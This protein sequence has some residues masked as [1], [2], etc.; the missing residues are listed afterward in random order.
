ML[1][2]SK[3]L[4]IYH[5]SSELLFWTIIS[6]AARTSQPEK[7]FL[8]RLSPFLT[9]AVGRTLL[10]SSIRL[11]TIQ[12]LLLLS[13]WPAYNVNWWTDRSY[14]LSNF[15]VTAGTY[16]GLQSPFFE[17]EYTDEDRDLREG[18]RAE[19]TRTWV[20]C[21][22]VSHTYDSFDACLTFADLHSLSVE[23]GYA[24][25]LPFD[26]RTISGLCDGSSPLQI[27]Q[28]LQHNLLLQRLGYQACESI[29]S[30]IVSDAMDR[31][32]DALAAILEKYDNELL[33]LRQPGWSLVNRVRLLAMRLFAQ[34]MYFHMRPGH[35][36]RKPGVLKA[37]YI[38]HDIINVVME[39]DS[40][41][42]VLVHSP[43]TTMRIMA[44]AA[45]CIFKAIHSSYGIDL[46][47]KTGR[48]LYNSACLCIHQQS[49]HVEGR[50][51][52]RR[53][54]DILQELWTFGENDPE[55]CAQEPTLN[56]KTRLGASL[57]YDCLAIWRHRK[58]GERVTFGK[59]DTTTTSADLY[60]ST[61]RLADDLDFPVNMGDF[62]NLLS[63]YLA[64][65]W[66]P[67]YNNGEVLY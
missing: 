14:A 10:G 56:T 42:Q 11:S 29:S 47:Y 25:K 49:V 54:R 9:T 61:A 53:T 40:D 34:C 19:R 55:M 67:N 12:A 36:A 17:H 38:A 22:I 65:P 41:N 8:A 6:I 33:N 64:L 21:L 43:R 13:L 18:E 4:D 45:Q 60:A 15:A 39:E 31:D 26:S 59:N 58:R 51:Q 23:F 32:D 30:T 28:D 66:D 7:D 2:P 20:C 48:T 16:L 46:H 37:C 50:D 62:D 35:P 52:P 1:D 27:P 57:I 3:G 24:T 63:D 44:T 5:E